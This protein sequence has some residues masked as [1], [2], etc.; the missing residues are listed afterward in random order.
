M[1]KYLLLTITI[2]IL[3]I[4]T[5]NAQVV[6]NEFS[7]ANYS[8]VTDN[9]SEYEDW[10]ELYNAGA[11]AVDLTGY[12]LSDRADD[13]TKW[14]IPSG[15]T[16]DAGGFKRF[17]CSGRNAI[18]GSH[19]HTNFKVTQTRDAE[20]VV[21]SDASGTIIDL[22]EIDIPNQMNHSWGRSPNGAD[23]WRIF[24]DPTPNASNT[25]A[26]KVNYAAKP[27]MEPNAG[28]YPGS[29]TVTITSIDPDVTIRYTTDGSVPT[30]TS[31]IYSGP[32]SITSTKVVRT[33]AFSS[34][35]DILPSFNSSNT[36]FIDE[37][38]TLPVLSLAGEEVDN[39]LNGNGWLQP[40]GSFELFSAD[41][42]LIDEA[43]GEYNEHGNDSWAYDQRGFDY[44]VRDQFGYDDD[45]DHEFFSDVTDRTDYQRLIAK[46]AA[47][48]NY[49]DSYGGAHIRDSYVHHLAQL[50]YLELDERS[51]FFALVF[52][53]GSYWGVYDIREKVDDSDFTDYYYNQNEFE[54]DFIKCWGWTW[55]E[56]GTMD[57]WAPFVDFV[58]SNDMTDPTNYAY[59]EDNLNTLSLVDY[60]ILNTQTVC[61]DWLNWNTGWWRGYD[62]EG[63][64][65][66]WRYILWD[67]DA[68][69]GHYVNY[70]GIPDDSPTAD[71][72]DVL[73]I[74]VDGNGHVDILNALLENETFFSLYVN[75]FADLNATT[76]SCVNMLGVLDSM[77]NII[78]PEMDRHIDKWGG[79]YSGW[80]SNYDELYEFIEDRCTYMVE[81]IEDC[82]DTPAYPISIVVEPAGSENLV[83]V[84]TIIPSAYPFNATYYGGV[85]FS[86]TALPATGYLFD[87]WEFL[88]HTPTPSTTD[89]AVTLGLTSSDTII[90]YFTTAEIPSY[91]F[92]LE[93]EPADAG[94][95]S[96][97][98]FTPTTYPYAATYLSGT[99]MDLVASPNVG[100]VFEYWELDNHI[101]NPDPFAT[102]VFFAMTT[103]DNVIAHFSTGNAV[104][105]NEDGLNAFSVTPN[106]TNGEIQVSYSLD[107]QTELQIELYGITGN[108]VAELIPSANN[109]PGN[110]QSTFHLSDY[111]IA[112]GVYF[113]QFIANGKIFTEKIMYN[114]Q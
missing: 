31:T 53:N 95:V 11:S 15:I 112:S 3:I 19:Y 108:R 67:E 60:F 81:G 17:W 90:A 9:H 99:I 64:A 7:A 51:T 4:H 65:L 34:D 105:E 78:E 74:Y 36:Y 22:N 83:K 72:C 114:A 24:T 104:L 47:N 52:V 45:I 98:T 59:V 50:D 57:D 79:S 41:F 33:A 70:T 103:F 12:Y 55:A 58:T 25:T 5:T 73:G 2:N 10:I 32:I 76:F 26:T 29:V 82:F 16:I 91:N 56:F 61:K 14:Q 44:I 13:P 54:I 107:L 23:D 111:G 100:Y 43:I 94:N 85:T 75:R 46:A 62:P 28:N 106:I 113:V 89:P 18:E 49:P 80:S 77:K 110:Y 30:A 71:P 101:A 35:A 92:T 102:D 69:F 68:T 66:T 20:A 84:N 86:L 88:H 63:S 97:N 1:K 38:V 37:S 87:H 39:L 27:D 109:A 21:L 93:I 8:D 48:D 42:E 96:V 40:I 6:I